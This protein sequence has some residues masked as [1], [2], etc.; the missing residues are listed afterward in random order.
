MSASDKL[1]EI[2]S[3]KRSQARKD[4]IDYVRSQDLAKGEKLF[5]CGNR[6]TLRDWIEAEES[7]ITSAILC[8]QWK[9]CE[10]CSVRR[11]KGV[12]SSAVPKVK[13]LRE[14]CPQLIPVMITFGVKSGPDLLERFD[15]LARSYRNM[16]EAARK[17][18]SSKC[19]QVRQLEV[20]KIAGMIR[21]IEVKRPANFPD[22]WLPHGHMLAFLTDYID[23]FKFSREWQSF[24]GDS[25]IVDVRKVYGNPKFDHLADP[26]MSGILEVIKYPMKLSDLSPEDAW[27]V[28]KVL[29]GRQFSASSGWLRGIDPG[30]ITKDELT[31]EMTGMF[32]DYLAQ[33]MD[34]SESFGMFDVTQETRP[35]T[36]AEC[37]EI[38]Y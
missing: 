15:H 31:P 21:T 10:I 1:N 37:A 23:V 30:D 2:T 34:G 13:T 29:K 19:R 14:A 9:L 28:H 16:M 4:R 20:S 7:Q 27:H 22:E 3:C 32:R 33:W 25:K 12:L 26:L 5:H 8:G 11:Q 38:P 6:L 24:S 18:K 35:L 17:A 36:L